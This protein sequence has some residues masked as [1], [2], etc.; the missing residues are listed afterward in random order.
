M[1][2][3]RDPRVELRGHLVHELLPTG[4]PVGI[5]LRAA[6]T[7]VSGR[8]TTTCLLCH[9]VQPADAVSLFTARRVGEAGRNGNTIG[10]YVCAD[11]RCAGR[12][13]EVPAAARHLPDDLQELAVVEQAAG[14]RQRLV[15]F[16]GD[17]PD[18]R[19]RSGAPAAR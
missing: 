1:L 13:R 19:L 18:G 14:L 5:A 7:R 17:V 10:T 11:L 8:R 3:R 16:S 6:G 4:G 9:A 15:A 12:V 2:G